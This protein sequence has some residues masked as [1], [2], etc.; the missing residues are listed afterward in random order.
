M[1]LSRHGNSPLLFPLRILI[2]T[3]SPPPLV[4]FFP[5][6]QFTFF[7]QFPICNFRKSLSDILLNEKKGILHFWARQ[8]RLLQGIR[9]VSAALPEPLYYLNIPPGSGKPADFPVITARNSLRK[10]G[11]DQTY[12]YQMFTA[13]K[14]ISSPYH[15]QAHMQCGLPFSANIVR[16]FQ[17]FPHFQSKATTSTA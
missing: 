9:T 17:T 2:L 5:K 3:F 12:R 6:L 11:E 16:L 8:L 4:S 10:M 15:V 14:W 7:H 13:R 1:R